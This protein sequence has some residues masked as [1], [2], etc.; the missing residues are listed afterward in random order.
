MVADILS[1]KLKQV[2]GRWEI[3]VAV[4]SLFSEPARNSIRSFIVFR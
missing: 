1:K 2:N 4:F 3:L